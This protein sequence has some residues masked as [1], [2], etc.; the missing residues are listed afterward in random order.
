MCNKKILPDGCAF[1]LIPDCFKTQEMCD[2]AKARSPHMLR[3]VPDLFK[4][5]EMCDKANEKNPQGLEDVSDH[6]KAENM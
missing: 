5:Q 3:H 2:E 1:F 4:A 6:F